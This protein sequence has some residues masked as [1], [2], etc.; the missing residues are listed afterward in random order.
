MK[1]LDTDS[2]SLLLKDHT[3]VVERWRRETEE[4]VLTVVTQIEVFQGRFATLLKAADGAEL[5]VAQKRLTQAERDL[6]TF[7]VLLIDD[8]VA[9]EFDRLR[10]IKKLKK[11][12]RDDLL[13]AAITLAN[14]ATLVTRNLKD[15]QPIPGLKLENWAD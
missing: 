13:I 6:Q 3:K 8:A 15:F 9:A 11:S 5:K 7:K 14:H 12:G 1:V 2:L 10:K 4:V